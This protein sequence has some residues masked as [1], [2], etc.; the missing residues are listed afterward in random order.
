MPFTNGK[1]PANKWGTIRYAL[2]SNART[3]RLCLIMLVAGIP[4]GLLVLLIH[5]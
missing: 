5:R 1:G 2:D 4:S 3:V